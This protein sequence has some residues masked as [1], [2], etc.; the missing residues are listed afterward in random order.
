MGADTFF[1]VE[2]D[3][4]IALAAKYVLPTMFEWPEFVQ[5]GG[6]MSYATAIDDTLLQVGAY[7]GRILKGEDPGAL[8]VVQSTIFALTVNLK[9][10][11][12]QGIVF[13][14]SLLARADE[15]IE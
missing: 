6:L 7:T 4:V 15:V 14:P 1:Q 2:R 11:R 9:T 13:P 12:E 8:P 5:A 3:R 10:A